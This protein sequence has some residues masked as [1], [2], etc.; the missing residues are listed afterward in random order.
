MDGGVPV[1]ELARFDALGPYGQGRSFVF[2]GLERV[3]EARF[4]A[5]VLHA[6][7]SV[8]DAVSGGLHAAGFVAYEAAPAFD[9]A[10]T[11]RPPD[12]RMPLVRFGIYRERVPS[13]PPEPSSTADAFHLGAWTPS[14][15]REAY[16]R[17]VARIR[18]WIAAGDTYQV[19]HTFRLRAPFAGDD[20]VLYARLVNA[21]RSAYCAHLRSGGVSLLS[22]SPELFFRWRGGEL[23]LRPMKGTRPRG[24]WPAEDRAVADELLHSA[25]DRAENLMIVDLLRND[26]GR[27]AEFGS[28]HVPALFDVER[29]ETVHQMTS[30]I[31]ARTRPDARLTEVFRALFPCGSIT[32]AP[33][34][35]T[36]EIIAGL[37]DSPR[38]VYTG[39]VGFASPGE[40]VFNVAIR[41]L[42]IDRERGTAEMGV[43][44]GI[45]YD[46][47]AA[48]E[49]DE[50]LSKAAFTRRAP[51]DF[52]LLET[53]L[54]EP[55]AGFYLLDRHLER[56]RASAD[57]FGYRF[58]GD[59]GAARLEEAVAS[60]DGALRV[61]LLLAR[62]GE[63]TVEAHPLGTGAGDEP[64]RVA[65][66]AEPVDSGDAML[67]HK[68]TRREAYERR[69]AS[70]PDCGDVLLVNERGEVT[71]STIANL[72]V[73][74]DG[75]RWT[76]P[77]ECG[78]LPGVVRAELLAAGQ[79]RE[80]VLAP[81]D[82]RAGD[83][84]WLVN[85][86]R[87]WRRAVLVD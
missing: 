7:E 28:V 58:D 79:V 11:V 5:D 47:D 77:L 60:A 30:T 43:G 17:D 69:A 82:L 62:D 21:Q 49:Y 24:R 86:V 26:A 18:E 45:T 67:Y 87:R 10:L 40:A 66:A 83:A 73:E 48:A 9:S 42:V 64:V 8:E 6:L 33:K 15:T 54:W 25:K 38:G 76:P 57:H 34:V 1:T 78:L 2:R 84:L 16:A 3:I 14:I 12:G 80:R 59:A 72:V 85:S 61:R 36:S 27:V 50:C 19:N 13:A 63:A 52:R 46:S 23:E 31:R 37:E 55:D 20:R 32:G 68:T 81:D 22:V 65:V 44:S 29:Y 51:A 35:R 70:R 4:V 39:A 74:M 41:T 71:E 75:A 56:M 53:I